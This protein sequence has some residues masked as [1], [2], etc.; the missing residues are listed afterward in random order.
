MYRKQVLPTVF[1]KPSVRHL[2]E[3]HTL[4][5]YER[6]SLWPENPFG[7]KHLTDSFQAVSVVCPINLTINFASYNTEHFF[8]LKIVYLLIAN[9]L[10]SEFILHYR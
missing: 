2:F 7:Y 1:R 9:G 4:R 5:Y 8:F 6:S 3:Y 10:N